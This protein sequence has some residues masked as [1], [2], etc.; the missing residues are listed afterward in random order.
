M[1]NA[2]IRRQLRVL[3]PFGE[4]HPYDLVVQL[5]SDVFL[6]IQCKTARRRN[7]CLIF[8]SRTTDHGRGRLPY[9]GLADAF[10]VHSQADG[11]VF[12]VPVRGTTT[13][14]ASLRL[15]PPRNNQRR[16]VRLAAHFEVD[17]WS[18]EA[19]TELAE[20][21][22]PAV[23]G[24]SRST[25]S[26]ATSGGDECRLA[27]PAEA[28]VILRELANGVRLTTGE[29]AEKIGVSRVTARERLTQLSEADLVVWERR[30][31]RGYPAWHLC[32]SQLGRSDETAAA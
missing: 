8:N 21:S 19:L 20:T 23:V 30:T 7:G 29:V 32:N 26:G 5:P 1:L 27:M 13:T 31:T 2:F 11:R 18:V 17:R 25:H 24:I 14:C 3:I 28:D 16:R 6:R 15:E 10:G 12:L 9:D 4:G 22:G